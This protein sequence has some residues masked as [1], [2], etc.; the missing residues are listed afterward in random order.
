MRH[1]LFTFCT[2]F[3]RVI[4]GQYHSVTLRGSGM[5]FGKRNLVDPGSILIFALGLLRSVNTDLTTLLPTDVPI[6]EQ[7]AEVKVF[8]FVFF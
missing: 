8:H 6:Q 3:D 1:E 4:G 5:G 7:L 2:Y